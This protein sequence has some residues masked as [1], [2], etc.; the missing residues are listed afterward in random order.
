M[1][2]NL[3]RE[4]QAVQRF[5]NHFQLEGEKVFYSEKKYSD[6]QKLYLDQAAAAAKDEIAYKMADNICMEKRDKGLYW[7]F[8]YLQ[9]GD[10]AGECNFT[11][12]YFYVDEC[13]E[14]YFCFEGCGYLIFWDGEDDYFVEKMF[15]GSVHWVPSKYARRIVNTGEQVLA[16]G[17]CEG[18]HLDADY[19]RIEKSGFPLRIFKENG[20]VKIVESPVNK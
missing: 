18:F 7:G 11:R 2:E 1:K 6:L 19:L 12:G 5:D 13:H 17:I 9:P 3:I 20:E 4:P 10:V 16:V 8:T 14:F 15:Q